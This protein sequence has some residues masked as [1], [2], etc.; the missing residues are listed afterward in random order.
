MGIRL[1]SLTVVGHKGCNDR[2]LFNRVFSSSALEL[3]PLSYLIESCY[4]SLL[5]I[6]F[7]W[8][9]SVACIMKCCTSS[10]GFLISMSVFYILSFSL[11]SLRK[12]VNFNF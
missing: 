6:Y 7:L 3:F 8:P 11:Y 10:T 9:S 4:L 2:G 1:F 5:F 12:D